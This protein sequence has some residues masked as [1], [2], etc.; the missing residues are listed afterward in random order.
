MDQ[1]KKHRYNHDLLVGEADREY[2]KIQYPLVFRFLWN[3]ARVARFREYNRPANRTKQRSRASGLLAICLATAGLLGASAAS[4]LHGETAG[5]AR[6]VSLGSAVC[7]LASVA[8]GA[9]GVLLARSKRSWLS[10]RLISER[11]RQLHFQDIARILEVQDPAPPRQPTGQSVESASKTCLAKFKFTYE[12]DPEG[13]LVQFLS[14]TVPDSWLHSSCPAPTVRLTSDAVAQLLAAYREL[15]LVHQIN[16]ATLKLEKEGAW[17]ETPVV[18]RD[19][20]RTVGTI[21]LAGLLAI[22]LMLAFGITG[23]WILELEAPI[24]V[25]YM[26]VASIWLAVAALATRGLL[27]GLRPEEEISRYRDYKT[28]LLSL[29]ERFDGAIDLPSKLGVITEVERLSVEET[30]SFL[31][32]ADEARFVI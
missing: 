18:Q 32:T 6:A 12:A 19:S 16:Y 30:C 15:R 24:N 17:L 2:A 9:F 22:H 4:L 14:D 13:A 20:L 3:Q 25:H 21:C 27:E 1:K 7:G 11:I 10:N 26:H 29:Q 28:S 8:I 23:E 31:R 5:L